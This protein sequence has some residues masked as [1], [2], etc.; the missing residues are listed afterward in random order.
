MCAPLDLI[1]RKSGWKLVPGGV[2]SYHP[3]VVQSPV[4]Y[5]I[6]RV[7]LCVEQSFLPRVRGIPR[8]WYVIH[9]WIVPDIQV[10]RINSCLFYIYERPGP[11]QPCTMWAA[12]S[13]WQNRFW[14][15]WCF[16]LFPDVFVDLRKNYKPEYRPI[17]W[18]HSWRAFF[19]SY[20]T[21]K[22]SKLV[23]CFSEWSHPRARHVLS[24]AFPDLSFIKIRVSNDALRFFL[25]YSPLPYLSYPTFLYSSLPYPILLI[26]LQAFTIQQ[27]AYSRHQNKTWYTTDITITSLSLPYPCLWCH[28]P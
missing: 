7:T 9:I 5:A 6:T 20:K 23:V 21:W 22:A 26:A 8:S 13:G 2:L 18:T 28:I 10:I 12:S 17:G 24:Q 25:Y 16:Q 1:C 3:C 4:C 27:S 19:V 14:S 15:I 11:H